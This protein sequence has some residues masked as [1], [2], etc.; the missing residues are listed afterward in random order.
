[1]VRRWAQSERAL[2]V[3]VDLEQDLA[4][5]KPECALEIDQSAKRQWEMMGRLIPSGWSLQRIDEERNQHL[6]RCCF[7]LQLAQQYE[8]P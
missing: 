6:W 1:M 7:A 8:L 5:L 3:A 4:C 2:L